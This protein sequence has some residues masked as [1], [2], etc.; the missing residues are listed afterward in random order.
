MGF[1]DIFRR[2]P[3][4]SLSTSRPFFWGRA[5]AGVSVNERTALNPAGVYACIRVLSE[6]VASL[7]L[8]LYRY[9]GAGTVLDMEHPLYDVLHSVPNPDM[10]SFQLRETLMSHILLWGNAYAQIIWDGAGRVK[11]LYPLLPNKMDIGRNESG[12]LFYTYWRE[13]WRDMDETRPQEKKGGVTLSR[14]DVL[15]IL[16]LSFDGLVGYSPIALAKNAI[17]MAIATENYG[18]AFF[19]NGAAP[20]G[21]IESDG[22]INHAGDLRKAWETLHM[23]VG[24]NQKIAVL[25]DGLKFHPVTIPPDQAQFLETR[26]FQLSEIARIFRVPPH[27]IGDLERSTFSNIEQQSL[28]F[29]TYSVEPW[30][31]RWEQVMEM[32]LLSREERKQYNIRFN[33]DGLLRA[34]YETRMKGFA[35]GRQNGWLSADEIRTLDRMNPLPPGMGGDR[36]LVNGNMTDVHSAEHFTRGGE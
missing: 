25:E 14:R 7:P 22:T 10:T 35:I 23:G 17:G 26:R 36:Y 21:V 16:G 4:D 19:A 11:Y 2:K 33:I 32:S 8:Q 13:Y 6:A 1:L 12:E 9:E 29:L 27:M 18:A 20:G 34:D 5:S 30:L 24:N 28:E 3:Q 31:I 15:H